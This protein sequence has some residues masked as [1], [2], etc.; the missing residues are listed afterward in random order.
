[1]EM[2]RIDSLNKSSLIENYIKTKEDYLNKK[3]EIVKEIIDREMEPMQE[4]MENKRKEIIEKYNTVKKCWEQNMNVNEILKEV[5][6]TESEV[7]QIIS[8]LET[9]KNDLVKS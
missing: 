4:Y 5:D 1:M 7:D 6:L 9:E 8:E 3:K 2:R